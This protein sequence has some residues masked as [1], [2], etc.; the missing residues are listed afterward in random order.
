[1]DGGDPDLAVDALPDIGEI[2]M[3]ILLVIRHE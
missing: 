2:V 1:M 3:A